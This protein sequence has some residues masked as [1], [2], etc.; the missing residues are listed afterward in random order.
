MTNKSLSV[1][2]KEVIRNATSST[3]SLH[4]V[5]ESLYRLLKTIYIVRIN[6]QSSRRESDR[7]K[8]SASDLKSL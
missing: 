4:G 7:I 8:K 6:A 1:L 3:Y 5:Y 2:S